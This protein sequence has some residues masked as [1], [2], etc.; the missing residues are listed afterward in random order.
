MKFEIRAA[1][2]RD[3]FLCSYVGR[4]AETEA[5]TANV[6]DERGPVLE[7]LVVSVEYGHLRSLLV[8]QDLAFRDSNTFDRTEALEMCRAGVRNHDNV[9]ICE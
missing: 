7:V 6:A 8:P 4:I 1:C 3:D 9:G 2:A 5:E